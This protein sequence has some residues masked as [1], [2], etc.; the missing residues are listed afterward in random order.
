MTKNRFDK[1]AIRNEMALTGAPYSVAARSAE[2]FPLTSWLSLDTAVGGFRRGRFYAVGA[3]TGGW[4]SAFA[5]NLAVKFAQANRKTAYFSL[6]ATQS[7]VALRLLGAATDVSLADL[8]NG[9]AK[10]SQELDHAVKMLDR[11]VTVN[12]SSRQSA[13]S[14]REY[15]ESR[16]ELEA[17][18][19]DYAQLL[20]SPTEDIVAGVSRAE[21][22]A[23]ASRTLKS[24]A[25]ELNIPVILLVQ[26]NQSGAR[27]QFRETGAI[28][29]DADCI[30]VLDSKSKPG[31]VILNLVKNRDGEHKSF[32]LL[33]SG[34]GSL[35]LEDKLKIKSLTANDFTMPW[36]E[37]LTFPFFADDQGDGYWAHGSINDDEFARGVNHYDELCNAQWDYPLQAAGVVKHIGVGAYSVEHSDEDWR[38]YP[39]P[40]NFP[41]A[42]VVKTLG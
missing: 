39:C 29:Q 35:R 38:I 9:V 32:E 25:V 10:S 11:S 7:E 40:P 30:F 12:D 20:D 15:V 31:V 22:L 3:Q 21:L 33:I 41:G 19:I 6:E 8:K 13:D 2:N 1:L 36:D 37:T 5:A 14:I 18:I 24:L 4:K 27:A 34:R 23:R 42:F 28:E 16:P 17:V 26:M